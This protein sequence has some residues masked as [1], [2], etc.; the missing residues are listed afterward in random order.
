LSPAP[1]A[2]NASVI[3]PDDVTNEER[4]RHSYWSLHN[5]FLA[6]FD[7]FTCRNGVSIH[8]DISS[9]FRQTADHGTYNN[10]QFKRCNE[11]ELTSSF[12]LSF[13]C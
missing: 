8:I 2:T 3:L 1:L 11:N 4:K 7:G 5:K 6:S 10:G 12:F 13:F 9:H